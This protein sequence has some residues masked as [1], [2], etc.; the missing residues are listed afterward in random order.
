MDTYANILLITIP[1]FLVLII[2][3]ISYGVWKNDQKHSYMDTI[4]SLSSG[5]TNLMVDILGLGIIILSY[6]FFYERLKI[7][8]LEESILLYF[9]AF[10]C[11][12]FASY[13]HHRLKHS[14]NIFWNMHVIHHSSEE[15]N[16]ACALRQSI[17]NNLGI[18]ILFLVPAAILG[19]PPQMIS[20]LGPLHLFGQFW[21]H[22]RHIGKLG[23]IEYVLVTPSQH[24]VHHA[25]NEEYIDKNLAAIFCVWDRA[26]GTFQEELDDVP[27]VYGTLKPVQTWNPILIN[28]QHIYYLIQDAWHTSNLVDKF[29]IW[30]MP[31]GW[32]PN[33]V[34]VK[35]PRSKVEDVFSQKKYKPKYNLIHKIFVGFHFLILNIVLYIFL[36]SFGSLSL[37]DKTLYLTLIFSTIFSFSS[38]MDGFKWSTTFEFLR[39]IIGMLVI[40]F[41]EE[42]I[43]TDNPT[44]SLFLLTYLVLSVILNF[45]ILKSV[46][47]RI[48]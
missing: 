48:S 42:L 5:F 24:R 2:I 9:I 39:I 29:K 43:L 37:A 7:I 1:I 35:I 46:P 11:V 23:W 47:S 20:I 41:Q 15:F 44:I 31:T 22:T 16:L 25:I 27:C 45:L 14:I 6:P 38:V 26:F 8:E 3:E 13:C 36:S 33:D 34:I 19:I 40:Y 28:F 18:G 32:R 17:T 30:F 4:S 12:D 10:V 21:Y